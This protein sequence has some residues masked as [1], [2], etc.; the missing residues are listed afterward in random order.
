MQANNRALGL[1][2]GSS[3]GLGLIVTQQLDAIKVILVDVAGDV[4]AAKH[5]AVEAVDVG[6]TLRRA[7]HQV[8]E[9]LGYSRLDNAVLLSLRRYEGRRDLFQEVLQRC[10]DELS[11]AMAAVAGRVKWSELPRR[12][13]K[14]SDPFQLLEGILAESPGCP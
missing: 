14:R 6:I 3:F 12:E 4:L 13:R 11:R 9:I 7:A 10:D 8:V 5:G 2:P 1:Q